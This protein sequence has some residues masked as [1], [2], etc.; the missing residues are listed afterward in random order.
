MRDK[1]HALLQIKPGEETMVSMLLTQSVFL[2]VFIGAFDISA[3]S[4]LLSIFDEK[5]MARGYIV[6]GIIGIIFTCIFLWLKAQFKFKRF[7]TFNF[8]VA[9]TLTLLLWLSLVFFPAKWLVFL[10]FIMFAPL[11]I[12]VLMAFWEATERLLNRE[13]ARRL[14][15]LADI[16]LISG[17][18]LICLI[19]PIL[20]SLKFKVTDIL[21]VS[22]LALFMAAVIQL[23]S[24]NRFRPEGENETPDPEIIRKS[25]F[26]S[27]VFNGDPYIRIIGF[28]SALSVITAIFIQYLFMALTRQLYPVAENMAGF[29]CLFT[30]STMI[31]ILFLKLFVFDF[32]LHTYGLKACLI[33]AP[34][35][36]AVFTVMAMAIGSVFGY[37]HDFQGGFIIF[38]IL[39][40][41][42]GLIAR[43]LNESVE[44]PSLKII[45]QSIKK[46]SGY[47]I[48]SG[49]TIINN[50]LLLSFAGLLLTLLG[51]F[52]SLN[53]IHFALFILII[54]SLWLYLAFSLYKEYRLSV[55]RAAGNRENETPVLPVKTEQPVFKNK[56][57][58]DLMFRKDYFGL[59]SG[60]YQGTNGITN[61]WYYERI[62]NHA[63][64]KRDINLVPFLKKVS[65][66]TG[67][68]EDI[69]SHSGEAIRVLQEEPSSS[70][71]GEEKI[72]EAMRKLSGTRKPLTTEILRLLRDSSVESKRLAILMIGKFGLSDLSSEVCGYL[73]V[74]D[75]AVDASEVLKVLDKEAENSLIRLFQS[76]TGNTGLSRIILQLLGKRCNSDICGFLFSR[77]WS[78]SRQLK[79]MASRYLLN[80]NFPPTAEELQRL[81]QLISEIIGINAWCLSA[82]LSLKTEDDTALQAE[83]KREITR[84]NT[85]LFNVLSMAY[86]P[87][88][89]SVI[90]ENI[91]KGTI[92]SVSYALE[93]TDTMVSDLIKP[94]LIFL[95][96]E[97]TDEVKLRNLYQFYGL[98][99]SDRRKILEDIINRDYNLLTLWTKATT[100]RSMT[101]IADDDMAESVKALLFSPEE[102]LREESACLIAR[103]RPE[104]Y[105]SVSERLPDSVKYHLSGIIEGTTDKRDL[106]FEKVK[107]LSTHFVGIPEDELLILASGMKYIN[108]PVIDQEGH[109]EG[110]IIWPLSGN[111]DHNQVHIFYDFAGIAPE[112]EYPGWMNEPYYCLPLVV[113][114]QYDFQ[115]PD[116]SSLVLKYIDDNES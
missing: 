45:N 42:A 39:I 101:G 62:I 20:L 115:Y 64:C 37:T 107:F 56:F 22:S 67:I 83:I 110:C 114:E 3:H 1:L 108:K 7:L 26:H 19:I 27:I 36:I 58:A 80:C 52:S 11:N 35:I 111:N 72:R 95:L 51:L 12:L 105:L 38:F 34:V 92:E 60:N 32:F 79:E 2:G 116:N 33:S 10:V 113:V 8:F 99:I 97:V 102:I 14:L 74:P 87:N 81:N 43:A 63:V 57:A 53:I 49:A 65:Q 6:S 68:D 59:I 16:G 50:Y 18:I 82:Q 46:R 48:R 61:K 109:S 104:L 100:L 30:G 84:W 4:L 9:A 77:L 31:M 85:F 13:Q 24:G 69:R 21:F 94:Q 44:I 88:T 70:D 91:A 93:M 112:S 98:E 96:D 40:A 15:P 41:T 5:I 78:N 23:M 90:K 73:S 28:F 106:L 55:F 66:N 89:V 76:T 75:L 86:N 54:A 17:T 47:E 103:S 29:L 25:P 71:Q